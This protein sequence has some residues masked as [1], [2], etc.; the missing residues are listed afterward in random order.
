MS[1]EPEKNP[2]D[3]LTLSEPKLKG[4][5]AHLGW[6]WSYWGGHKSI[7]AILVLLTLVSTAVAVFYPLALRWVLDRLGEM[8]AGEGA[9]GEIGMVLLVLVAT[10]FG[11]FLAGFYPATRA[12][13][14]LWLDRDIR[15]D[16]FAEIMKKDYRFNNTFRT[17]DVVTRLTDDIYEFPKIS[18]FGCSGIFRAVESS[19][20]LIF[21]LAV[22]MTLNWKLT[23]LSIIPLPFMMWFF[24]SLRHKIRH[25]VQGSQRA[26]SKTNNLLEAAFSGIRIVK[27]F[28]AEEGQKTRLGGLMKE[29]RGIFLNLMKLQTVLWSLDTLAS[30]LGQMIVIA[31]GGFMVINNEMT[32][33]TLFAFFVFLDM[34][35]HPMMDLPHLFMTA[36]QAFVSVD[37]VEEIRNFP[38]T[39]TRHSGSRMGEVSQIAFEDVSFSYDGS[40][41]SVAGVSF[42]VQA[43]ERVAV[44][45]PVASGKS[46]LLK[47]MAGILEPSQGRV[48]I[49]GRP[50]SD[51]D[52]DTYKT[53]LGYVPQ[54]GVLFS[55]SIRE[56]VVFGRAV[57]GESREPR[58]ED[59]AEARDDAADAWA[60]RWL[61]VAQMQDDLAELPEGMDTI[62]GQK[63]S[64]V[65]G[66][67]K[68][69]IAIARALAGQP[70]LLLFDDCT[71]ALD[72]RNEDRF[73]SQLDEELGDCTCFIVSHR[74]ATIRRADRILVL[75]DGQLVDK[76]THED[77][78][79]RCETYREFL[80][81]ERRKA[82][83]KADASDEPLPAQ[84]G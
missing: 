40:R 56:N 5:R 80:R 20:K 26:I 49:N 19:S 23:L 6:I 52:W 54:E 27:A 50:L 17:G 32:I 69:R 12:L 61:S 64:L 37:R 72:A 67:Q 7:I 77:L 18:W 36:Q 28:R 24:Y 46:T 2:E 10:A 3:G 79:E 21:C 59:E 62:V 8:L 75:E 83:L 31:V 63:G 9:S 81:T 14:N 65:S 74:L 15:E 35:A 73:W 82:Q 13:M 78:A 11:R 1:T 45:G 42:Q 4:V 22:M 47:L 60:N 16:V 53:L 76:G 30:R 48:V 58:A 38:V 41:D 51:W 43:G 34:L 68:Q 33:G 25:Y 29:R 55:K 66:G 39:V 44:V 70:Q 57:P 71:A 84:A